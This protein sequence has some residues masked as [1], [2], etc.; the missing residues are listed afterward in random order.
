MRIVTSVPVLLVKVIARVGLGSSGLN[1]GIGIIRW[2]V[3]PQC[4]TLAAAQ[5]LAVLHDAIHNITSLL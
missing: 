5:V 1:M 4:N 3:T 2:G